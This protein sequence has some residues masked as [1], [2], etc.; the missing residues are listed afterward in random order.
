MQR[1][2][3][4]YARLLSEAAARDESTLMERLKGRMKQ[5]A[6]W[7]D[8]FATASV[9][10]VRLLE[11]REA[12]A[13]AEHV[14]LALAR[15]HQ[16]GAA[17]ADLSFW[18]QYLEGFRS[19]KAF[20]LVVE[21]LLAKGD[22][23]AAMALLI[24]WLGQAEQVRLDDGEYSFHNL[25]LRWMLSVGTQEQKK[26]GGG[27]EEKAA[28]E[29][30]WRLMCRFLDYLEANAEEYWEVP[31]LDRGDEEEPIQDDE[32]D[33]FGAA[34]EGVTYQDTTD[35]QEEAVADGSPVRDEFDLEGESDLLGRR[36]QFLMTVARLWHIASRR[37]GRAADRERPRGDTGTLADPG[38]AQPPSVAEP[39]RC[40][41]CGPA[42]GSGG[43]LRY[44]GGIRSTAA[45]SR[46]RL[47]HTIISTCLETEL[48]VEGWKG[49]S[50]RHRGKSRPRNP[51]WRPGDRWLS[52]W[53]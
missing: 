32:E 28:N 22:H 6:E 35:D 51:T 18:R 29:E 2:F 21:A 23:R 15:W 33:L 38:T 17:S 52:D 36:L 40:C 14:A 5:L 34:Y 47:L 50:C 3:S 44:S 1:L 10:E 45:W 30:M 11:G 53:S 12:V 48:A 37:S 26:E 42:P 31:I 8:R 46:N 13:S 16:R 20:A 41:V 43:G 27:A 49:D 7:W 25:A 4:L 9:S 39:P 19:P 24:N